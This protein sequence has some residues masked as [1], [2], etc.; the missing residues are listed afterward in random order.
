[1]APVERRARR[2]LS[3][4]VNDISPE[5]AL[6]DDALAARE[7]ARLPDPEDCLALLWGRQRYVE[8]DRRYD[9]RKDRLFTFYEAVLRER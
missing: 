5:L 2:S 4:A 9:F 3:V 7:R 6:V 1:M 8:E